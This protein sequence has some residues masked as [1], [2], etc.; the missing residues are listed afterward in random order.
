MPIGIMRQLSNGETTLNHR[1]Q[2]EQGQ[3]PSGQKSV[4]QKV[5]LLTMK[6][7]L[8]VHHE[9]QLEL[10]VEVQLGTQLGSWQR[11]CCGRRRRQLSCIRTKCNVRRL[12]S[13]EIELG[14]Q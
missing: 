9:Q 6:Y 4:E 1:S 5:R 2:W 12:R 3:C 7:H 14:I 8:K 13:V 11:H 10:R